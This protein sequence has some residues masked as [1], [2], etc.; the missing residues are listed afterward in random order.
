MV[1]LPTLLVA[2]RRQAVGNVPSR[3]SSSACASTCDSR[4]SS[5]RFFPLSLL[6]LLLLLPR[7]GVQLPHLE[8]DTHVGGGSPG[9]FYSGFALALRSELL[10][11]QSVPALE[12]S[13]SCCKSCWMCTV[14]VSASCALYSNV[15]EDGDYPCVC[16]QKTDQKYPR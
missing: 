2:A 16:T 7:G 4:A 11:R 6:R 13:S 3:V 8:T 1:E 9:E 12:W 15:V 5:R 10:A 14:A